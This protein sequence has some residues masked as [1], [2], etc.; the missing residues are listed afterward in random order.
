VITQITGVFEGEG[1]LQ[2]SQT[3]LPGLI[4]HDLPNKKL[5]IPIGLTNLT[6]RSAI[7]LQIVHSHKGAPIL[8]VSVFE[9][10]LLRTKASI[11]AIRRA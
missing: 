1:D 9:D 6:H 5:A 2:S 4:G 11:C 10:P 3:Q 8:I 7:S